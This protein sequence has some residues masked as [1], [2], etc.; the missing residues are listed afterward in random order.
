MSRIYPGTFPDMT[1]K[2]PN[3]FKELPGNVPGSV[4]DVSPICPDFFR[5]A[6]RNFR[7]DVHQILSGVVPEHS[8]FS[9]E[10]PVMDEKV[11]P[12][13]ALRFWTFPAI[14]I[15]PGR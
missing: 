15:H 2:L 9:P 4:L 8:R 12:R 10:M 6:F 7:P 13:Q 5:I 3:M 14:Y 11:P 1:K